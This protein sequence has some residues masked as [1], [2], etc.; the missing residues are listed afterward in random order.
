MFSDCL[1]SRSSLGKRRGFLLWLVFSSDVELYGAVYSFGLGRLQC[2][3]IC[4]SLPSCCRSK[5][6]KG[7]L[8][9]GSRY[10]D[11]HVEPTCQIRFGMFCFGPTPETF[12]CYVHRINDWSPKEKIKQVASGCQKPSVWRWTKEWLSCPVP[13]LDS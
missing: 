2:E 6:A 10:F 11:M 8:P 9:F 7:K 3:G 1:P 12:S 5:E 13:V 4:K